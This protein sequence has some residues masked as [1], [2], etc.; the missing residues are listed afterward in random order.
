M[1]KTLDITCK[2]VI[3]QY[4][5]TKGGYNSDRER[6][7]KKEKEIEREIERERG[8]GLKKGGAKGQD[9]K[10]LSSTLGHYKLHSC[11]PSCL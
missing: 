7:Q 5:T 2:K 9:Y 3:K 1:R 11:F 4:N 10:A 8:G 6:R